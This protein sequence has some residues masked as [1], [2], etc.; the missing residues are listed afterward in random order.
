MKEINE[1]VKIKME[2]KRKEIIPRDMT[3]S[4]ISTF[5]SRLNEAYGMY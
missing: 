2:K 5:L 1:R 4:S 3:L